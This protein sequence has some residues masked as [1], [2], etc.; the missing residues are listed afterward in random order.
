VLDINPGSAG[1]YPILLTNVNGALFFRANDGTH[2]TELWDPPVNLPAPGGSNPSP[3]PTSPAPPPPVAGA[4]SVRPGGS[5]P[6]PGPAPPSGTSWSQAFWLEAVLLADA[7]AAALGG[8]MAWLA[9]WSALPPAESALAL[10]LVLA[11]LGSG[12]AG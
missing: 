4:A 11:G 7:S 5:V 8:E 3:G 2:G 9:W 6:A 12:T 10:D 1:S